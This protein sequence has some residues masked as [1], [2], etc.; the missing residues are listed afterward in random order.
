MVAMNPVG[1]SSARDNPSGS[2]SCAKIP[3]VALKPVLVPDFHI[4]QK[5]NLN[6]VTAVEFTP[7]EPGHYPFTCGMN[8]FQ[9]VVEVEAAAPKPTRQLAAL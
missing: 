9:G 8:M 1:L 7:E 3:V 6:Q 5:L 2:I 4:A